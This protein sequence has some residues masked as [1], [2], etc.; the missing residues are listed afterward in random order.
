MP[1]LPDIVVEHL[2]WKTTRWL[3][4]EYIEVV[5]VA[6]EAGVRAVF[7]NVWD[8]ALAAILERA[9]AVVHSKPGWEV[10]DTG[11][12]IVL[13]PWAEKRLE[14]W[15]AAWA[16]YLVVGG[17]MGDHPPRGRTRYISFMYTAAAK[18]NLGPHQLSVD[19]AARVALEVARG[20]SLDEIK[21]VVG[22]KFEVEGLPGLG[23]VEVELPF[24]Y[25]VGP[26]G[27]PLI[28][29]GVV[30]LLKRGIAWDEQDELY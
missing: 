16:R 13:D 6:R 12:A 24:A 10:L 20:S 4:E 27:S 14:P 19:G 9:G 11:R 17:I 5:R 26:D 29:R 30:A 15:E 25:P 18:R 28:A 2:E 1:G 7:T 23:S 21:L 8:P 3:V 22:V